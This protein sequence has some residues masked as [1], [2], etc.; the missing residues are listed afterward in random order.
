[1]PNEAV[2]KRDSAAKLPAE[3]EKRLGPVTPIADEL[4]H[5][6]G[7]LPIVEPSARSPRRGERPGSPA[8]LWFFGSVVTLLL[9]LQSLQLFLNA[10]ARVPPPPPTTAGSAPRAS[11]TTDSDVPSEGEF[12]RLLRESRLD[13]NKGVY[14]TA[15]RLL[16]PLV[17]DPDL[18][19]KPQR[20]EAYFL[21]CQAHRA[22]Q[23]HELAQAY[24]LKAIDQAVD[25]SAPALTLEDAGR[26]RED[27]R[28][29]EAREKLCE[30]LARTDGLS[31]REKPLATQA[32]A[33]LADA[34]YAQAVAS[35]QLAPL[36]S[37]GQ[38]E[39]R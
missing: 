16:E 8:A 17:E 13:L 20:R 2:K 4:L 28:F 14:E 26:L 27:G 33:R 18:L 1:M 9:I 24:Y 7:D 15:I 25:R 39:S 21:L 29:A 34:W 31:V 38:E 6:A 32:A 11:T 22:L 23:H 19:E 5:A 10:S 36:P 3:L 35:R 12:D 37:P 30:L